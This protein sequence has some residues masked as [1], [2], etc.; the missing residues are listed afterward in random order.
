MSSSDNGKIDDLR[1]VAK[2]EVKEKFI[3]LKNLLNQLTWCGTRLA[4]RTAVASST[5]RTF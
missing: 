3:A 5:V 4:K 1:R 2:R